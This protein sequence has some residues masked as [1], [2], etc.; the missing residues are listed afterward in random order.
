MNP[1]W[2]ELSEKARRQC[3]AGFLGHPR[4]DVGVGREKKTDAYSTRVPKRDLVTALE[5]V[6]QS[7]RLH[8][9]PDCPLQ[10][11]LAAELQS[12]EVNLNARAPCPNSR[13][14]AEPGVDG[15]ERAHL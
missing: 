8:V 9:V 5:V 10:E 3:G 7:R 2:A 15:P 6:L 13:S 1:S 12:F 11:D 4:H 14:G